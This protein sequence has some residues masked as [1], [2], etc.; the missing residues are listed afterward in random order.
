M[1]THLMSLFSRN[2][3]IEFRYRLY[4]LR[5]LINFLCRHLQRRLTMNMTILFVINERKGNYFG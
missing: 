2:E 1:H 3:M 4:I 5:T